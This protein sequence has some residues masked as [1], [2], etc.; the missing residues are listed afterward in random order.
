[1]TI[2]EAING[3]GNGKKILDQLVCQFVHT[4]GARYIYRF[5]V[6]SEKLYLR[7]DVLRGFTG[8]TSEDIELTDEE[9]TDALLALVEEFLDG[10]SPKVYDI[11]ER[12]V[13]VNAEELLHVTAFPELQGRVFFKY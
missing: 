6:D 11:F 10:E 5:V 4:H 9:V 12:H 13:G 1:M 8:N 7:E 2:A 3:Y